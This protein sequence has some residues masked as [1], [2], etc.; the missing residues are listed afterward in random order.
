M[1]TNKLSPAVTA[2]HLR[3]F[4]SLDQ[5]RRTGC[6]PSQQDCTWALY[7]YNA[8]VV[9]NQE[10]TVCITVVTL[11]EAMAEL[12]ATHDQLPQTQPI[13]NADVTTELAVDHEVAAW[14]REH[15]TGWD[16]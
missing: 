4:P 5:L 6:A 1:T 2:A 8:A 10:P 9:F 7:N 16:Y 11:A 3:A 14:G 15:L 13:G 12:A